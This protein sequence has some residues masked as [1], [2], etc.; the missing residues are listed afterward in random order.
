MHPGLHLWKAIAE[1]VKNIPSVNSKTGGKDL[2]QNSIQKKEETITTKKKS[3]D[4]LRNTPM[5]RSSIS[6]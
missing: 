5:I 3:L 4:I 6:T 1:A 2:F